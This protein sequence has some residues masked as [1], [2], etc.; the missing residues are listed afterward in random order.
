MRL[1]SSNNL[2]FAFWIISIVLAAMEAWTSRYS[3]NPMGISYLDMGDAFMRGDWSTALNGLWSPLYSIPLGVLISVL[4]PPPAW[5]FPLVHLVNLIIFVGAML[6]FD[7]FLRE[8]LKWRERGLGHQEEQSRVAI[9][10][11]ALVALGYSIFIWCSLGLIT[12]ATTAPDLLVSVFVYLAFGMLLRISRG[13]RSWSSFFLLGLIIGLGYLA[14]A[15][16]LPLGVLFIV[17]GLML[18]RDW[19]GAGTRLGAAV[20]GLLL[21]AG[22]FTIALS[23]SRHRL[24][25]GDSSKLNYAWHVNRVPFFHWQG[26]ANYG[27]PVHPT[28]KIHENPAIYEFATPLSVT[29]PPWYDPSYWYEGVTPRFNFHQQKAPV[30]AGLRVYRELITFRSH[31]VLMAGFLVLLYICRKTV[32]GR[33][34][35]GWPVL[36]IS[37]AALVLFL[38][39]HVEPRYVAAFIP[40][41]WLVVFSSLHAPADNGVSKRI[42]LIVLVMASV[43]ALAQTLRTVSTFWRSAT[44]PVQAKRNATQLQVAEELTRRGLRHGDAVGL[45]N[46]NSHW[47]PM[48]HWARLD[49]LRIVAE[50]PNTDAAIFAGADE[51]NQREVIETMARTGAR[52]IVATHVPDNVTL[53]GWDRLGE[54]SYYVLKLD[55]TLEMK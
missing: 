9:P 47:L 39:V 30:L 18:A 17:A 45:C 15:P 37:I 35:T 38:P 23:V 25:Y 14:K 1:R 36:L 28:R 16:M 26:D 44:D 43:I 42:I 22:P 41:F 7:F 29:Y 8:L 49:R 31:L 32:A 51:A 21:I 10:D 50:L 46:F 24:T 54:T 12:I 4:N 3:V 27:T 2:R 33:I 13:L 48:V 55:P 11:W 5:E 40:P 53:T 6:A 52:A 20:L 19:R 34:L